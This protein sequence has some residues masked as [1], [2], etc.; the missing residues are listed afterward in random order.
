MTETVFR[1]WSTTGNWAST[2][3]DT[4]TLTVP[5]MGHSEQITLDA[6]HAYGY[7]IT[8]RLVI[9]SDQ[10]GAITGF[11]TPSVQDVNNHWLHGTVENPYGATQGFDERAGEPSDVAGGT[12]RFPYDGALN[13]DPGANGGAAITWAAGESKTIVKAISRT[14]VSTGAY[15]V[16]Q[17]YL[18]ISILPSNVCSKTMFAPGPAD[19]TAPILS[20]AALDL[21]IFRAQPRP[22]GFPTAAELKTI[23]PRITRTHFMGWEHPLNLRRMQNFRHYAGGAVT[24]NFI[25]YSA[26]IA[27]WDP[28]QFYALHYLT[29]FDQR[30]LLLH[31]MR[32]GIDTFA[33]IRR[34][35]VGGCGAGMWHDMGLCDLTITALVL[36]NRELL[37]AAQTLGSNTFGHPHLVRAEDVGM[38]IPPISPSGNL[39]RYDRTAF[40]HD[41]GKPWW[42]ETRSQ[43]IVSGFQPSARYSTISLVAGAIEAF[44]ILL[45]GPSAALG[46]DGISAAT[47]AQP[48]PAAPS[49]AMPS[50]ERDAD[51]ILAIYDRIKN[52]GQ[53]QRGFNLTF[54]EPLSYT[55]AIEAWR[56][57]IPT[58][59]WTGLPDTID[60]VGS[61]PVEQ[62]FFSAASGGVAWISDDTEWT[63]NQAITDR[64]ISL[65]R[66]GKHWVDYDGQP[67]SGTLPTPTMDEPY[68][69][70]LSKQNASGWGPRS[71][72]NPVALDGQS[73]IAHGPRNIATPAAT[74]GEAAA[75]PLSMT[76]PVLMGLQYPGSGTEHFVPLGSDIDLDPTQIRIWIG[77]GLHSGH[78]A[79]A[80]TYALEYELT[81]GAGD[82]TE[83]GV[84]QDWDL[85]A[86]PIN[87]TGTRLRGRKVMQNASG[88]VTEYTQIVRVPDAATLPGTTVMDLNFTGFEPIHYPTQ[89]AYIGVNS[90]AA[91]VHNP[92]LAYDGAVVGGVIADK[93]GQRPG[94]EITVPPADAPAGNYSLELSVIAG[95]DPNGDF[96]SWGDTPAPIEVAIYDQSGGTLLFFDDFTTGAAEEP[97]IRSTY[98]VALTTGQGFF[99][100]VRNMTSTGGGSRGD[101]VL[102]RIRITQS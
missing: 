60:L 30:E 80:T 89:W 12:A 3:A 37:D 7:D 32:R 82:W 4:I 94:F 95:L 35:F 39:F 47:S 88:T 38:Y 48:N 13:I 16:I 58:Y 50:T 1:A 98:N 71:L 61:S 96:K 49:S 102:E 70:A 41:V 64:R 55:T 68:Y 23:I 15:A 52:W 21:S 78:P 25:D 93:S 101:V 76:A 36:G 79:P 24:P 10:A 57:D 92:S 59:G 29:G 11:S 8:G 33:A 44:P 65:S 46:E 86:A 18:V 56:G 77:G 62:S 53:L 74:G 5:D 19:P 87:L 99:I 22:A 34:G 100:S 14:D 75:A 28:M 43:R 63:G 72:S 83:L 31:I 67:E 42:S 97:A 84:G 27:T 20:G 73:S 45:C 17:D 90:T 85:L 51:G 69:C 2:T 9:N 66:D 91:L 26:D 54:N 81:P 40:D 6:P